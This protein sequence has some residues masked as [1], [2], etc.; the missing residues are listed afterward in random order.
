MLRSI[1]LQKDKGYIRLFSTDYRPLLTVFCPLRLKQVILTYSSAV[2]IFWIKLTLDINGRS[3]HHQ[4]KRDT[5]N[6]HQHERD[7]MINWRK[8]LSIRTLEVT[9][10]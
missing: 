8:S 10:L 7:T 4:Y 2:E 9:E 5:I 3:W 6:H 1:G